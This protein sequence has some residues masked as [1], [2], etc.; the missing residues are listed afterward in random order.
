MGYLKSLAEIERVQKQLAL[1][2]LKSHEATKSLKLLKTLYVYLIRTGLHQSNFA[3]GNFVAHCAHVDGMTYANQ[4]FTQMLEPNSFV[5]NTMI[6]GFQQNQKPQKALLLFHCMKFRN[7]QPDCFTFPFVIRACASLQD[8]RKGLCVHGQLFKICVDADVYTATSLVEF[9]GALGHTRVA[10][11]VFDEIPVKDAVSWTTILATYVNQC[12]EM[13]IAHQIFCEMPAKD[14]VAWNTMIG[15][16]VKIGDMRIAKELF[17]QAPVKDLLMYNT[18]LGG[19]AKHGEAEVMLRFFDE[20]P[21]RD[22]VSWNSVIGGLVQSKKINEA[23]ALFH[24]MQIEDLKPNEV[25]LVAILSACAQVGALDAGRWIN[26]YIDRNGFGLNLLV[27]TALVDMYSKCGSLAGAQHVFERMLDRDVVTWNAMIMGFSMNGQ[28]R[29]ALE[30]FYQM[31]SG[32]VKPNEVT[33]IGVLCACTHAG[34]VDEGQE[35]FY[36]MHHELGIAPKIEHYGCM[37]DL[38]GRA[39]LLKQAYEFIQA[40][41]LTPHHG[42]WGALLGACKIH[43]N[44]ELAEHA[45]RHLIELDPEDGGY[46]AI[47]SNIYA[48]A[49]RWDDVAKVRKLMKEKGSLKLR[50]CSSIEV[51]SEIHEF[52]VKDTIHPR[53]KEIYKMIDEM[54]EQLR[55]AGHV[56]NTNE[57]FF[58]VEEEEKEK[59]LFFHSEKLA[60]AFGLIATNKGATLR[61]VKNL[62]VCVD[63]HSA[64]KIISRIFDRE[65]VVRDRSR[66]H[67]FKKG[68]CSCGDYW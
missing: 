48:N 11:Q 8:L 68:S 66:F 35:W 59:A 51:D 65:I 30:L 14:L 54:S 12:S 21:K 49:G 13:N 46:L 56:A 34:L 43:G 32:N 52:G 38:L 15:G 45:I 27:G 3:I 36:A 16:Y 41:P 28:S 42:V 33:F 10:H 63:C 17:D 2:L 64:I 25:T 6:R 44:V 37:V 50:G 20:M 4:V 57:V 29:K 24:Q 61:I 7:I 58:D 18:V 22:V 39:G 60:I 67:H 23:I 26:S 53:A 31:G 9:Y 40:M 1:S 5:W 55:I 19:Y 47:M 62:R